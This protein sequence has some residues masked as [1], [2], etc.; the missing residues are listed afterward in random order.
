MLRG[1]T[2]PRLA[3]NRRYPAI[4]WQWHRTVQ[5]RPQASALT[6]IRLFRVVIELAAMPA[7]SLAACL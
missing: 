5:L 2:L 7:G 1:L 3:A 4:H 6:I